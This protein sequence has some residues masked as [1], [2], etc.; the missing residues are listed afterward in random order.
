MDS[1]SNISIKK[2]GDFYV[3]T[4]DEFILGSGSQATVYLA[5][6]LSDG[7][8]MAAKVFDITTL[9]ENDKISIRRQLDI[10]F[11]NKHPYILNCYDF[12]QTLRNV[13]YILK[14][15]FYIIFLY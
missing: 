12:I 5:K 4:S 9:T 13:N 11:N 15:L 6:R 10:L 8:S 7:L 1:Q 3:Y 2:V 14:H